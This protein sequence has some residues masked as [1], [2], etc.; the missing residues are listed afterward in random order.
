MGV[1]ARCHTR[2]TQR[3]RMLCNLD[4]NNRALPMAL[5]LAFTFL[6]FQLRGQR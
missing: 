1:A 5:S 6:F 4:E 2:D 3:A